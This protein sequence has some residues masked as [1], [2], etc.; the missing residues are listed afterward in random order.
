[1]KKYFVTIDYKKRNAKRA[2]KMFRRQLASKEKRK[3]IRRYI[4]GYEDTKHKIK[5]KS[6]PKK[7][8][9]KIIKQPVIAPKDFRL[10]E[11]TQE[12]LLFFR[13]IR[14]E[15][16]ISQIKN[17]KLVRFSLKQIEQIDYGTISILTAISDNLKYQ[18]II[19]QGDF[20]QN[21]QCKQFII[22]SGFLNHMFDEH[23]K[24]FPKAEKSDLIFFEKG[25]GILSQNDNIK[26]SNLVKNVVN[27]LT[28]KAEH[29]LSVK[30]IILEICGNSIEWSGT[31]NKQ[32]LLG[33]K[34]ETD[35]VIFTVIDVGKGILETLY[36]RF[37]KRFFDT[38]KSSDEILKGAFDKKYGSATQKVNRN[39]GLP[40]IKANFETGNVLNLK[41]LTN[42]VILHFDNDTNSRSFVNGSPR[43][44]GTFY[45]WEMTENCINKINI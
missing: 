4:S 38:F 12:C 18:N 21:E 14:S 1:M 26:I 30:T 16:Y 29:S 20:P 7:T 37:T 6:T 25:C 43:F 19:L 9:D 28:G 11:N 2:E 22:D 15:D 3:A 40:S 45:Q 13:N 31:D 34:Y 32:W 33:V 8:P 39:K 17:V 5:K 35:K 36:R 24:P 44:K 23:N 10:I 42:N 41:V 27:H